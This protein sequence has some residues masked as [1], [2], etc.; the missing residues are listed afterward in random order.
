VR[1]VDDLLDVSR[2]ARGLIELKRQRVELHRMVAEAIEMARPLIDGRRHTMEVD[3]DSGL[4]AEADPARLAQVLSNL[5]TNAAKYTDPGGTIRVRG[6]RVGDLLELTVEDTGTGI[7]PSL[8]PHIFD[9]FVQERQ[10]SDRA[11]GGMGLGLSIVR[12]LIALHGGTVTAH[13]EGHGQGSR[14][15]V[16][17]PAMAREPTPA[18]GLSLE[19]LQQPS[20]RALR[21]LVVDDNQDAADLLG[22]FLKSL[23]HQPEIVYDPV[24]ALERLDTF[25]PELA[26]V[27]IG[28]PVMDGHELARHLRQR[29]SNVRLVAVT[30]YGQDSDRERAVA[31]GFDE[32]VVKPLTLEHLHRLL[33]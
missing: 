20:K 12:N 33:Q 22:R 6:H 24:S 4:Y 28:L 8:L 1:L 15:T 17:L 5:I 27:D 31:A 19:E 3:V 25:T 30:G 11:R 2:I 32:H 9:M 14:F 7:S 29:L 21:V 18:D 10:A 23:G 13:S 16:R 26:L